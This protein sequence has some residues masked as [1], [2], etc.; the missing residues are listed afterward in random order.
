MA[1]PGDLIP[2][3]IATY[4]TGSSR[5]L[6]FFLMPA[7]TGKDRNKPKGKSN[8]KKLLI[9]GVAAIALL[10][11]MPL[12]AQT[13]VRETTTTAAAEPAE[14]AGTVTEFA[15]DTVILQQKEIAAPVRYSFAK[16][17]EYVDEAGN[18]VTREVVKT[19]VPVTVR[20][21]K[22][23]DRML[24]NR[25]IVHKTAVVQ[26]PGGDDRECDYDHHDDHGGAPR[27]ASGKETRARPG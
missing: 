6:R 7:V 21:I 13:V 9:P 27:Q 22:E 24:V 4:T 12:H 11:A 5:T 3:E 15:P 1:K 25:V 18:P 2:R 26:P 8:M 19:G 17:V 16:T 20:Y 10:C 23:G 14:I